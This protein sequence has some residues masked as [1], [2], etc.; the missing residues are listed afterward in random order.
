MQT[1]SYMRR[2]SSDKKYIKT[3]LF[4]VFI[5]FIQILSSV[6]TII[7]PLFGLFFCYIVINIDNEEKIF[8]VALSFLYLIFFD[9]NKGF[10]L[11]SS[12]VFFIVFYYFIEDKIQNFTNCGNCILTGYIATAYL[13]HFA[14]NNLIS[15]V[16]NLP[17]YHLGYEYI[18]YILFD[19]FF[20]YILF[21]VKR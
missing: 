11:F 12:V 5:V 8:F 17:F 3:F 19:C 21:E 13:G 1:L 9:L 18:Y 2:S 15:Y 16:L 14:T 20:S 6:Y 7:P 4:A 10:Y